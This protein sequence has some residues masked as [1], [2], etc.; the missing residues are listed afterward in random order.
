MASKRRN[1]F[2]RNKKQETTEIGDHGAIA[3]STGE[4]GQRNGTVKVLKCSALRLKVQHRFDFGFEEILLGRFPDMQGLR[5]KFGERRNEW[6]CCFCCHVRTG[7]IFL[8]VWHLMLQVLAM[9]M[10]LVIFRNPELMM[11]EDTAPALPTP[12]S[13][14]DAPRV[15]Q[16]IENSQSVDDFL[17]RIGTPIDKY[18]AQLKKRGIE[19]HELEE[20]MS[21]NK[22]M[23]EGLKDTQSEKYG[24]LHAPISIVSCFL[25]S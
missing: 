25:F 3:S 15:M 16:T 10:L 19:Y 4:G 7:T 12:L 20:V 8:G 22:L 21:I 23:S 17:D 9:S 24:K 11:E 2:Y 13:E 6:K 1:M 14:V 18:R 5:Y